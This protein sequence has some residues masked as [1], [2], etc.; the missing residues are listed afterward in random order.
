MAQNAAQL[1]LKQLRP[2][3]P[4]ML[5]DEG[6]GLRGTPFNV[7]LKWNIMPRIGMLRV[8]TYGQ[9]VHVRTHRRVD[10]GLAGFFWLFD[11]GRVC[12]LRSAQFTQKLMCGVG[13]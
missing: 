13:A 4:F 11:A 2:I 10:L 8:P 12:A 6:T 9:C 3:Y 1:K 5:T 7:S